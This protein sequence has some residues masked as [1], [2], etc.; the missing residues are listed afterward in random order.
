MG[1]AQSK[2]GGVFERGP[3]TPKEKWTHQRESVPLL[4]AKISEVKSRHAQLLRRC[5]SPVLTEEPAPW[6]T[7]HKVLVQKDGE[8]FIT[9]SFTDT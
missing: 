2:Q 5:P 6:V 4:H 7:G 1:C 3:P 8:Y 9:A